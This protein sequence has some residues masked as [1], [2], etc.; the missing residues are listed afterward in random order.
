VPNGN[1]RKVQ[2]IMA[3]DA[4]SQEPEPPQPPR[5]DLKDWMAIGMIVAASSFLL[6]A[7]LLV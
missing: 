5:N 6:W 1:P 3:H 2:H 4:K 7:P